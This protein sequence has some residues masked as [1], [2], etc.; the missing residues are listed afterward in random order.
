MHMTSPRKGRDDQDE[1][2]FKTLVL[3]CR[4]VKRRVVVLVAK[5]FDVP[6]LG[7]FKLLHVMLVMLGLALVS[8]GRTLQQLQQQQ[9]RMEHAAPGGSPV[10]DAVKLN[11]RWRAERNLWLSAFAFTMWT[12]LAIF[13]REMVRR[14]RVEDRLAEFE[15]SDYTGTIDT[16]RDV[17]ISKEVTS[18]PNMAMLTPRKSPLAS[19]AKETLRDVVGGRSASGESPRMENIEEDDAEGQEMSRMEKKDQ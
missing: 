3:E 10:Y 7:V 12:V 2:L 13:Y 9:S 19:P 16:T 17:S 5:V 4:P 15:T 18:R 8:A 14:L 11:K 1:F 6:L